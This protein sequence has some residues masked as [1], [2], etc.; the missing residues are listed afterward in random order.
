MRRTFIIF[1]ISLL[2]QMA[3]WMTMLVAVISNGLAETHAQHLGPL[4]AILVGIVLIFAGLGGLVWFVVRIFKYVQL[5]K[6][7]V[8]TALQGSVRV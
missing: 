7:R 4:I 5:Q 6:Q 1:G 3:G 8:R 2:V